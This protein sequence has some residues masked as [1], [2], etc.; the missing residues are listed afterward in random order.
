VWLDLAEK[1]VAKADKTEQIYNESR[2][3]LLEEKRKMAR[4]IM[5]MLEASGF[6]SVVHGS[7]ARG[8]VA[9]DSDV[10]V[11]VPQTIPS[12]Q[13][14][15]CLTKKGTG[16]FSRVVTQA[17]P[18]HS[19]KGHIYLD[20][21]EMAS[22][23]FPLLK[24]KRLEYEFYK[25]GGM[26]DLEE[27][28]SGLRSP[29]VTKR[30]TLIEPTGRGHFESQVIGRESEVARIVGVSPD[31]VKERVRVLTRRDKIGRTGVFLVEHLSEGE[32]FEEVLKRIIESNPAVRRQYLSRKGISR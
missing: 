18:S 5:E 23:T 1:T 11:L 12:Y 24:F 9:G 30:L 20:S 3:K 10:D 16:L 7:V 29:G 14:E 22:V 25:F 32:Q 31:I 15:L 19:P 13:L 2:W 6:Q 26:V 21:E 8:D 4:Q 28:H 17:T 27:L